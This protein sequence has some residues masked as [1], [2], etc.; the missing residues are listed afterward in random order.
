MAASSSTSVRNE[1][2]E[3]FNMKLIRNDVRQPPFQEI[4][5]IAYKG[6]PFGALSM[7][8][9]KVLMIQDVMCCYTW[10]V[11]SVGDMEIRDLFI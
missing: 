1:E 6:N 7:I 9:P 2:N 10:K 4:P 11:G 3:V 8:P 5:E